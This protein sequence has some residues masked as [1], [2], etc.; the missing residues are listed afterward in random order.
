MK[1]ETYYRI[2]HLLAG[3]AIGY[4]LFHNEPR[5]EYGVIEVPTDFSDCAS[6]MQKQCYDRRYNQG[7][8]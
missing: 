1:R 5:V 3:I 6:E 4:W 7:D 2:L 8:N